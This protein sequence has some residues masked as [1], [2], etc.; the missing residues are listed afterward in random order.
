[1]AKKKQYLDFEEVVFDE[2]AKAK[3][4]DYV[5]V[6]LSSRVFFLVGIAAILII[7][8]VFGRLFYLNVVLGNFYS[9]RSGANVNKETVIPAHRGVITDR[10][11]TVLAKNTP[12][13]SVYANA[14]ELLKPF[15]KENFDAAVFQLSKILNLPQSDLQGLIKEADLEKQSFVLVERNITSQ[16]AIAI[17]GLNLPGVTVVDDYIREYVDGPAFAHIIGFTAIADKG[18]GIEGKSGLELFYNDQLL[19]KN[20]L[21]I[22]YRDAKGNIFDQKLAATAEAGRQ[23]VTTIDAELQK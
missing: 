10:F 8:A 4:L 18:K 1:M 13:L 11:G 17:K 14:T 9:E 2:Q 6:L 20:G 5:E 23:L 21:K 19:G 12:A 16:E 3:N 7:A 22:D 15:A